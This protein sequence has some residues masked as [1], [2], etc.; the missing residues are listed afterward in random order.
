MKI[1]AKLADLTVQRFQD[2]HTPFGADNAKPASLVFKGEVYSGLR[3]DLFSKH[4]L[5][6]AQDHL[7]ILSGLY[8]V[9]RPLDLMQPYRLEMGTKLKTKR[10]LIST[11]TG[12]IRSLKPSI[13]PSKQPDKNT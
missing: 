6:Y 7:R 8:G 12:A 11:R 2:W 10:E 9:L 1:N 13:T 4:D 5:E 3:A